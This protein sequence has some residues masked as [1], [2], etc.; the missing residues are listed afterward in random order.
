MCNLLEK[1]LVV[2]ETTTANR[3]ISVMIKMETIW[4][5]LPGSVLCLGKTTSYEDYE[6]NQCTLL[7]DERSKFKKTYN[8]LGN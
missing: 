6:H 1:P 4:W 2:L 3:L 7:N 8:M 5:N